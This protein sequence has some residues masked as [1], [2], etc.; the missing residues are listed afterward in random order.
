MMRLRRITD[1]ETLAAHNPNIGCV[2]SPVAVTQQSFVNESSQQSE[3]DGSLQAGAL[4]NI[5]QGK[6]LPVILKQAQNGTCAG[7]GLK[8]VSRLE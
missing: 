4:H 2:L 6:G 5:R 1:A 3:T 8:S 7:N